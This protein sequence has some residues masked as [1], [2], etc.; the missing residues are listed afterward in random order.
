MDMLDRMREGSVYADLRA[1][2]TIG[3]Q[4]APNGLWLG[5]HGITPEELPT[6]LVE[7]TMK[8]G[9]GL[10]AL[11]S[12]DDCMGSDSPEDRFGFLRKRISYL[13]SD[14]YQA[15]VLDANL[16]RVTRLEDG[17]TLSV[18]NSETVHAPQG[19]NW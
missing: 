4:N 7:Q 19:D 15:V 2:F 13:D 5:V 10:V 18:L 3:F 8:K 12:E 6:L 17:V 1:F 16:L 11:T 9:V 14:K